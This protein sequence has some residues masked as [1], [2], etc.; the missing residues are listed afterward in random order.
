VLLTTGPFKGV[1]VEGEPI[2][3]EQR[4]FLQDLTNKNNRMFLDDVQTGRAFSESQLTA[5]SDGRWYLA[6]E[7]QGLGLVDQ[8]GTLDDVLSAIRSQRKAVTMPKQ[9]LRSAT[10]QADDTTPETVDVVEETETTDESETQPETQ[11]EQPQAK[12]LADYMEAFGD[13]EGARMFLQGKPWE[14]AQADTMQALRGELQDA[15]AEVAQLKSRV[16][17]LAK[18]QLGEDAPLQLSG[19][20]RKKSFG[21]ACRAKK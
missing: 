6:D 8:I 20:G 19:E 12:G 9:K 18:G 3:D 21:E 11:P 15:R 10:A 7:A 5:V 13:A 2:T 4:A 14:Q 16:A 1:G 17:E